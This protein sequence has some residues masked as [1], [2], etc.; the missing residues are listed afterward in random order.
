MAYSTDAPER[1]MEYTRRY[2]I[3]GTS[4]GLWLSYCADQKPEL[5]STSRQVDDR[6]GLT[7]VQGL[8]GK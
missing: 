4:E 7:Q 5:P 1:R 3:E 2:L 8:E 6:Q